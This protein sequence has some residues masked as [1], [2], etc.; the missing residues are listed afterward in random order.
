MMDTCKYLLVR[1]INTMS[2]YIET[3]K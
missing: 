3:G 1:G 2:R